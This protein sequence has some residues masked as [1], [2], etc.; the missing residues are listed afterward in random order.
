MVKNLHIVKMLEVK[1]RRDENAQS[2]KWVIDFEGNI[3]SINF[4][5]NAMD[6]KK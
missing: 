5:A 3:Y 1:N 6:F 2:R 4:Q